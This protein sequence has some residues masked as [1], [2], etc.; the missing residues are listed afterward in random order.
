VIFGDMEMKAFAESSD[1]P[2]IKAMWTR[3]HTSKSTAARWCERVLR[4]E[5]INADLLAAFKEASEL[6]D[7]LYC[8]GER[9]EGFDERYAKWLANEDLVIAKAEGGSDES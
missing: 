5:A 2:R 4:L 7:E 1:D 3:I 9:P 8:N 6:L